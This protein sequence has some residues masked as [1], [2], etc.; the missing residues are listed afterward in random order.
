M[1][2]VSA[3]FRPLPASVVSSRPMSCSWSSFS[4]GL[5]VDTILSLPR[6]LFFMVFRL[7]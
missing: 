1:P 5:G 3:D 4:P 6:S 2:V 7:R